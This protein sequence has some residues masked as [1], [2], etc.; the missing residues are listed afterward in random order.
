MIA[1]NDLAHQIKICSEDI[2]ATLQEL[3]AARQSS[4][5]VSGDFVT[6]RR[7][8]GPNLARFQPPAR[9]IISPAPADISAASKV[10]NQPSVVSELLAHL[11]DDNIKKRSSGLTRT[12]ASSTVNVF[13]WPQEYIVRP[14]GTTPKYDALTLPE[15][16]Y[17]MQL[18]IKAAELA[19]ELDKAS[20]LKH[21]QE[22]IMS[23]LREVEYP[24]VRR[25][26]RAVFLQ[27]EQGVLNW[28]DFAEIKELRNTEIAR[29]L[30]ERTPAPASPTDQRTTTLVCYPYQRNE[31]SIQGQ[32]HQ[33]SR[34]RLHHVCQYCL[35][36][37]GNRFN[38]PEADCRRKKHGPRRP[39]TPFLRRSNGKLPQS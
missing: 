13:K 35:N 15:L 34:G 27:V 18:M 36:V 19:G 29:A 28:R 4:T 26:L 7:L 6:P 14:N 16:I 22:E 5:R 23:D 3:T 31:C 9:N 39:R 12:L 24:A 37:T 10:S 32:A 20:H 38:H 2:K 17:G 1:E 11:S 25:S 21:L 33:S 30:R 8:M